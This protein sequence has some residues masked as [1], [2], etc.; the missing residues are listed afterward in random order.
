MEFA[1]IVNHGTETVTLI[2]IASLPPV[3]VAAGIGVL[4]SLLQALTQVQE[5][6]LGFVFKL[7]GVILTLLATMSSIG[8]N[9]YLFAQRLFDEAAGWGF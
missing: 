7:I 8:A 2:L 5:Q 9:F 1:T 3:V 4:V 6:T